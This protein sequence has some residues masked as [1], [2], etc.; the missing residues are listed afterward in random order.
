M[1]VLKFCSQEEQ[2]YGTFCSIEEFKLEAMCLE[3]D[4]LSCEYKKTFAELNLDRDESSLYYSA[5]ALLKIQ[6]HYGVFPS[7]YGKGRNAKVCF[8]LKIYSWN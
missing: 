1:V 6:Q 5:K 8:L 2:V 4:V 3:D 7:I